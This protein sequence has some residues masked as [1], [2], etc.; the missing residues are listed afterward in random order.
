MSERYEQEVRKERANRD[1]QGE[2]ESYDLPQ[3]IQYYKISKQHERI[4]SIST[5]ILE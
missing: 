5:S 4:Y 3:T 1:A 2:V